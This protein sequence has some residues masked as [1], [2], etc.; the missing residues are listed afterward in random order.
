MNLTLM[1]RAIGKV[2]GWRLRGRGWPNPFLRPNTR[3][4]I[5]PVTVLSPERREAL[6]QAV[7]A[8]PG[9]VAPISSPP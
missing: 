8:A 4:P 3:E 6:R 9:G 2:I 1:L 5:Y 7:R